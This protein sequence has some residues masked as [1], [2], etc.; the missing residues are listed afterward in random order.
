[1]S[2]GSEEANRHYD[3]YGEACRAAM[4]KQDVV[5]TLDVDWSIFASRLEEFNESNPILD[6]DRARYQAIAA[7]PWRYLTHPPLHR[8]H[9]PRMMMVHPW[10]RGQR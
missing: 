3:E 8:R 4:S 1:M 6:V 7:N 5:I 10:F 2:E 9:K